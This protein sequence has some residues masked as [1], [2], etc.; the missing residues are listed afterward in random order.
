[1]A[2]AADRGDAMTTA[3]AITFGFW[4]GVNL[5]FLL[6]GFVCL[7]GRQDDRWGNAAVGD[8]TRWQLRLSKR[9]ADLLA[10]DPF[11]QF[12]LAKTGLDLRSFPY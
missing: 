4:I 11:A 6:G 10:S 12:R 3:A 1:M 5:G 8:A 2:R 9:I 7:W